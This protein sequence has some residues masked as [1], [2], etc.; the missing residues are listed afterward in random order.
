M[1]SEKTIKFD[2]AKQKTALVIAL[3]LLA[4]NLAM[5]VYLMIVN[6][7]SLHSVISIIPCI[8]LAGYAFPKSKKPHTSKL[9][10]MFL[11]Q[12]LFI[13]LNVSSPEY[14]STITTP[15][16]VAIVVATAFMAGR[17]EKI[18]TNVKV[19]AVIALILL[20]LIFMHVFVYK[21]AGT[22]MDIIN[23][24]TQWVVLA[25]IYFGRYEGNAVPAD[26]KEKQ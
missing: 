7:F 23:H 9:R 14:A 26:K 18:D 15:I 8:I 5:N 17:L 25:C 3:L 22:M 4:C 21:N 10:T 2:P 11:V 12:A 1:N 6:G 16:L 13:G 24:F 20:A 19:M